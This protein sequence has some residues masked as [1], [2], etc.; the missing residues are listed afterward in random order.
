MK[1]LLDTHAPEKTKKVAIKEKRPWMNDRIKAAKKL[2]RKM[3]RRWRQSKLTVHRQAYEAQKVNVQNLLDEAK[4]NYYNEKVSDCE[5]DQKKLFGIVNKLIGKGKSNI[6]P[7]HNNLD[8]LVN[9]FA[10]FFQGKIETIRSN[11]EEL[12]TT[13]SPLSCQPVET[14]LQPKEAKLSCFEPA[15]EEE[16]LKIIKGSSKATCSL[17]P[18]PTKLLT[19]HFLPELPVITDIV[20]ASL[21]SGEFPDTLK[22]A[23]VKPLLK[24]L[25]LDYN[26][27]KNFRP[28]SNLTFLSKVIERVAAKRFFQFLS[29]NDLLDL[30]QSAYKPGHSTE[31]ALLR[32]QNDILAAIDNKTGV[33]LALI[34]LSAAFDTVD[35]ELLLTFLQDTIGFK[36]EVLKWCETYL[37]GRTQAVSIDDALSDVTELLFGVPQGSVMGP[38]KFC[39]YTLPIGAIIRAHEL[40]YHIYADD[41]QVYLAFDLKSPERALHKLTSCLQDIRTW[42]IRNKLKINDDKTEFLIIGSKNT[43]SNIS[44]N[45]KLSVGSSLIE[46]STKAK[47]LGVI[48]DSH[49]SMDNHVTNICKSV[50]H[51]LRNIGSI[52]RNLTKSATEQLVHSLISSRLDYCNS[53]LCGVPDTQLNRLQRLQNTA[54]RIVTRTAKSDHITPV[55]QDLHW[56]PVKSRI[57]FKVLLLTHKCL[58][59]NAPMY[60]KELLHEYKPGRSLRSSDQSLL[61]IP[62][63][64]LKTF[65][66]RS[67]AAYAPKVW[68]ALPGDLRKEMSVDSFKRQLKTYLFNQSY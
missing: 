36:D 48:F 13:T 52:R 21:S 66:D 23:L 49:M 7:D 12:E 41:T 45:T 53:L 8:S 24:K 50:N 4:Q 5:G 59:G 43:L 64:K 15:T 32:V 61:S 2:K 39:L 44:S 11:L 29:D 34:D 62:R 47:N 25:S 40:N 6:L 31:T 51:H 10:E 1:N 3:E 18:I 38:L 30:L 19:D 55:L 37:K 60:L 20:N 42:M 67:F 56:L 14:L 57:D 17:D 28:V 9:S 54:A 58:Y 65:G 27:F 26:I 22:T 63:T 16:I 46:P 68:N 33:F 35:H